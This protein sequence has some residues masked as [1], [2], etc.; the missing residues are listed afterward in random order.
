V[1]IT[2]LIWLAFGAAGADEALGSG[3]SGQLAVCEA[4]N[5]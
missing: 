5:E 4:E 2:V 3:E 1:L